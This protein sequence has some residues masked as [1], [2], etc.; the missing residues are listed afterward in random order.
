MMLFFQNFS[1]A[2]QQLWTNKMR[3]LLTVL[4]IIIGVTS[5]MV[6]VSIVGGFSNYI[7]HFLEGLGTNAM[8]VFPRVLGE[9]MV[10]ADIDDI[11][12]TCPALSRVAPT[13][14]TRANVKYR[15]RQ[16]ASTL[17]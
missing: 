11:Q 4:G 16:A 15:N 9:E 3:S 5:T 2:L 6:V 13:Q 17:L 14:E 1:T 8:A 7:N 10:Q 12:R